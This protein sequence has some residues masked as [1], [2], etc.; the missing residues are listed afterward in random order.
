MVHQSKSDC[1]VQQKLC[2]IVYHKHKGH[3]RCA[4]PFITT[5]PT[6]PPN[7]QPLPSMYVNFSRHDVI[8]LTLPSLLRVSSSSLPVFL[9]TSYTLA[10]YI[11]TLF[12]VLSIS[13]LRVAQLSS[14]VSTVLCVKVR[15]TENWG[16]IL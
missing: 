6:P 14:S 16:T 13:L 9:S 1:C 4:F 5:P 10:S 12:I 15:L 2:T 11:F 8:S 7:T 3:K